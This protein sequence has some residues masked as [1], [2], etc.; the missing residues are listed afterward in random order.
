MKI[1]NRTTFSGPQQPREA[2]SRFGFTLIELIVVISVIGAAMA[3]AVPS[4]MALFSSGADK[5]AYNLLTAQMTAARAVAI[6]NGEYAGVHVQMSSETDPYDRN[7]YSTVVEKVSTSDSFTPAANFYPEA[8]PGK[9]AFGQIN[10]RFV[11]GSSY[12]S[13]QFDGSSLDDFT[14]FT[15]VFASDGRLTRQVLKSSTGGMIDIQF[16]SSALFSGTT[17]VWNLTTANADTDGG[18]TGEQGAN[19]ATM[20]KYTDLLSK[21]SAQRTEYLNDYGQ[22]LPVNYYTGQLFQR[23]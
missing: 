6:E 8:M 13:G 15:I 18:G 10:S 9:M 11:S 2:H 3:L 20:F 17:Q 5:Q 21:T 12:I 19:A 7:C 4:M 1:I 16:A 22:F 23:R 14:T